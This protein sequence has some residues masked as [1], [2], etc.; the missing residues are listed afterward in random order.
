ML[1]SGFVLKQEDVVQLFLNHAATW[2]LGI[3]MML[4]ILVRPH[5]FCEL[6]LQSLF[7]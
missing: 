3:S 7:N 4:H 1:F 2:S 6:Q 5:V